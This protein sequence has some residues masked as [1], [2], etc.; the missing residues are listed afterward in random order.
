LPEILAKHPGAM[1]WFAGQYKDV[2]GEEA[3]LTRLMPQIRQFQQIGQWRFLGTLDMQQ[4]AAFYP[5][6]DLLVV[7]ST[8]STETFGFVQIEA[9]MIGKPAVA[10]DLPGVR[11]PTQLSGMG[12]VS[13]VGDAAALAANILEVLDHPKN[14]RG[15]AQELRRRFSPLTCATEHEN[16]FEEIANQIES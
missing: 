9:M 6:I 5:N 3:Y 2:M 14:Y 12:R 1:V 11:Q 10:A 16:L 13:P 4:M 7:P 15:D 8:N